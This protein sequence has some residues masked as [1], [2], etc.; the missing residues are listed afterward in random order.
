[1]TAPRSSTSPSAA[2]APS[3]RQ[4][5]LHHRL[6]APDRARRPSGCPR[7][8]PGAY[9]NRGLPGLTLRTEEDRNPVWRG[10]AQSRAGAP[11]TARPQRRPGRVLAHRHGPEFQT[12]GSARHEAAA[13]ARDGLTQCQIIQLNYLDRPPTASADRLRREGTVRSTSAGLH[14]SRAPPDFLNSLSQ[15]RTWSGKLIEQ[16]LG[17]FQVGGVE[18]SVNQPEMSGKQTVCILLT[19]AALQRRLFGE[20]T[21]AGR[22]G[23]SGRQ[24]RPGSASALAV[25]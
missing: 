24:T 15:I 4:A 23:R 14:R 13:T 11:Q 16:G 25:M 1:M 8:C 9:A 21:R 17:I 6:G 19:P 12:P 7:L 20:E 18:A 2:T 10:Q 3:V 22:Q 5:A